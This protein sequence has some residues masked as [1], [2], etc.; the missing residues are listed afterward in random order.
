MERLSRIRLRT[1]ARYLAAV[2]LPM[3]T[4]MPVVAAQAFAETLFG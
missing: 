3:V 2:V 1:V 4:P